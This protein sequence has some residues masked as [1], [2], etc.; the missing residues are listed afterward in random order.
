M[1]G[2]ATRVRVLALADLPPGACRRVD[3]AGRALALFRI[4]T[5]AY[6]IDATCRHREGPLD[7]GILD[8]LTV[9]CPWHGWQYDLRTGAC[10]NA[11]DRNLAAYA[12]ELAEDGVY[13]LVPPVL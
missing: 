10:L 2:D 9:F 6:A 12:V 4:G 3:A 13:V 8:G 5:D 7:E 1:A 11:R